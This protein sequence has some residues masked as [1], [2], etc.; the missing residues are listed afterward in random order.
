MKYKEVIDLE[1]KLN[2]LKKLLYETYSDYDVSLE[3]TYA[4]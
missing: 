3:K 2:V 1:A 4:T